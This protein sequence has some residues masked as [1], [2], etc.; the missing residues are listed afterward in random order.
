MNYTETYHLPQWAESDRIMMDDFNQMCRDVESGINSV[1]YKVGSYTGN[2]K[3]FADGGIRVTLG[4]RPRFVII[5]KGW[6]L[7]NAVSPFT[8][9]CTEHP[10]TDAER[11]FSL[12]DTGF[13]VGLYSP[14]STYP[15]KLNLAGEA[16]D[17]VAFR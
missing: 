15:I 16:Y 2:G 17:F 3:E 1:S 6:S 14:S 7:T 5:S 8:F 12:D 13:T 9:I 11:Y 10:K 4:F